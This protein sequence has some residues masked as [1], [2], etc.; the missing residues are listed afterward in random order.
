MK[1]IENFMWSGAGTDEVYMS[2][3]AY[4]NDLLFLKNQVAVKSSIS[5]LNSR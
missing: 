2:S 5:N 1:K 4:Y 3:W